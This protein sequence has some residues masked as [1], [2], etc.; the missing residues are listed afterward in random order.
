MRH[1]HRLSSD[2]SQ[3]PV[4]FTTNC[5]SATMSKCFLQTEVLIKQDF[6]A[7]SNRSSYT[8]ALQRLSECVQ[9]RNCPFSAL[10]SPRLRASRF[11][12]APQGFQ[13]AINF[14]RWG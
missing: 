9:A 10:L 1:P 5:C 12:G 4:M 2:V 8:D 6:S 7:P 13:T 11:T 3:S 14:S